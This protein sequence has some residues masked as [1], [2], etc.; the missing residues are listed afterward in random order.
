M[1]HTDNFHVQPS[2]SAYLSELLTCVLSNPQCHCHRT[3][4]LGSCVVAVGIVVT[5]FGNGFV[6]LS[7]D[8]N[9]D[10]GL[11]SMSC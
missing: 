1:P 4:S 8:W 10:L 3:R 7:L 2:T 11:F 6:L 9:G 5:K